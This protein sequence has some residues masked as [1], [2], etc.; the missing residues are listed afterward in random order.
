MGSRVGFVRRAAMAAAGAL[1]FSLGGVAQA[2]DIG[3]GIGVSY[4]FG[5]GVAAGI[6]AFGDDEDAV[7]VGSVGLDYLFASSA[8][9]PNIGMTYQGEGYFSGGDVGYNFSAEMVDFAAGAG[10]SDKDDAHALFAAE[11]P[12]LIP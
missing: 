8:F 10:W 2:G 4:V 11:E 6:K 9:R 1:L 3:F 12:V 5:G 7:A